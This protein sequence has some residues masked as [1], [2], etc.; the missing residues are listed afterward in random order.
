MEMSA[1]ALASGEGVKVTFI[2][3]VAALHKPLPVVVNK[4]VT[5]PVAISVAVGVY[6]AFMLVVLGSKEPIPP[7]HTPPVAT[8]KLP[9]NWTIGAF[10]QST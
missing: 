5:C 4:R 9:P 1:P 10:E 8:V 6:V 7:L 3:S 2:S